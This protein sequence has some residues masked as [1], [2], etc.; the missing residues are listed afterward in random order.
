MSVESNCW[1]IAKANRASLIVDAADY[2]RASREAMLAAKH[3]IMLIGW[4]FDARIHL[5]PESDSEGPARLGDFVLWLVK[6]RPDLEIYLLRWDIGALRTLFRGTTI[7]TLIKWM[8]HDRIHT[9][10]DAAHPTGS[11]HHQKIVVID[12]CFAFCG[13]IDMTSNRW[14]TREHRDG[15]VRRRSPGGAPYPPWH[16]ATTA[17]QGPVAA[18]LGELARDRW[19]AAGGKR[20]EPLSAK[21]E[22]WPKGLPTDFEDVQVAI[23]RSMPLYRERHPVLEIEEAYL[24]LIARA[25]RFIYAE[26]QYFAS[27]RIAEAMARRLEEVDGPEIVLVNPTLSH[28]WLEPIAMDTARARL[29]VALRKLDRH[30]RLRLYHPVTA[31]GEPVYVHAKLMI[32]DDQ[33]LHVGSSNM[34]NRSMR[35]DTECDV[36]ID[37]GVA[38]NETAAAAITRIR[39]ELMAEHLGITALEVTD[40]FHKAG[41]LIKTIEALRSTGRSLTPYEVPNLGEVEKWLADN[42]VLD[43]NG[44][45]ELFEAFTRGKLLRGLR[46]RFAGKQRRAAAAL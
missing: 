36:T 11:S 37:A 30:R 5:D 10:L 27:R 22:C 43:P 31:A 3:R 14:D 32:V 28:G 25:Q 6:Q 24:E 34:N 29:F 2:F 21:T 41:A 20:L 35:L 13:G 8:W 38:G 33:V 46:R 16:D 18:I 42:E 23:S 40:A 45:T 15:D 1:R 4:D 26:N 44:P 12:D 17:L 19:R 7:F 9:R 39:T